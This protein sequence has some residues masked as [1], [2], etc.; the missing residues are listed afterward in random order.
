MFIADRYWKD[1]SS[2]AKEKPAKSRNKAKGATRIWKQKRGFYLTI[3][4]QDLRDGI[5]EL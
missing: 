1:G 2:Q 4:L 5:Q 3:S